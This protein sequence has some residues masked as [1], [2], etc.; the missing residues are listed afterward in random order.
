MKNN[1]WN[2]IQ[3]HPSLIYCSSEARDQNKKKAKE[4]EDK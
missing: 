2:P 4:K 1:I 3:N